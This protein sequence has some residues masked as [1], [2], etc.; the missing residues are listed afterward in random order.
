M[1]ITYLVEFIH[2]IKQVIFEIIL[3]E[4]DASPL[5]KKYFCY[6]LESISDIHMKNI[7]IAIEQSFTDKTN[8]IETVFTPSYVC[9]YSGLRSVV[10]DEMA[11]FIKVF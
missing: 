1:D 3:K 11:E 6:L 10:T 4:N 8:R 9:V 2:F 7:Q 5:G